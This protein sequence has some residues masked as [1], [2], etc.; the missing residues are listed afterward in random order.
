MSEKSKDRFHAI[1]ASKQVSK[2]QY[3][4]SEE[5]E[6]STWEQIKIVQYISVP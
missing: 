4:L 1:D 6:N 2:F 3:K 5:P